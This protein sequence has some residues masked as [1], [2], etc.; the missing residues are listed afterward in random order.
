MGASW[1]STARPVASADHDL[2]ERLG[3]LG[4]PQDLTGAV[5]RA[6]SLVVRRRRARELERLARPR[7]PAS[8]CV[9][10]QHAEAVLRVLD[11][12]GHHAC[13][14]Q[15]PVLLVEAQESV[16][17]AGDA[18]DRVAVGRL[19]APWP[20]RS[21]TAPASFRRSRGRRRP[22]YARES[23][24]APRWSSSS[25][26]PPRS[27]SRRL[28]PRRRRYPPARACGRPRPWRGGAPRS[29]CRRPIDHSVSWTA[30]PRRAGAA[31]WR[32]R[33]ARA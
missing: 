21:P 23:G 9:A 32:A 24:S 5:G 7:P 14:R 10:H 12:R 25:A 6:V 33:G 28:R 26:P 8:G 16:E 1:C 11:G 29:P 30:R 22:A 13:Q 31:P 18:D 20:G 4:L 15:R 27:R 17:R 19:R 3:V 2:S